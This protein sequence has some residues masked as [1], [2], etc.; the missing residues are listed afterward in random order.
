MIGAAA[1]AMFLATAVSASLLASTAL[2]VTAAAHAAKPSD[3]NGD[4]RADLAIGVQGE[5]IGS[6]EDAGAVNVLYGSSTGLSAKGNQLWSQ[7]SP[8]VKGASH[9]GSFESADNF[10][11]ALASG[12][13]DRDG[14]ADLAVGVPG[15]QVGHDKVRSGAVNVL[16]GS[17]SGLAAKGDQ[18][19][20]LANLPGVPHRWDGFG[21]ALA[22]GDFD[23]DGYWD[24]A[25]GVPGRDEGSAQYAGEAR[26]LYGGPTGLTATRAWAITTS[27]T[28]VRIPA[29]GDWFASA[30]AAGDVTGDGRADLAIGAP[31]GSA[32][33][34][35]VFLGGPGGLSSVGAQWWTQSSPGMDDVFDANDRFG[36]ALAIGDFDEDGHHDLAI[37]TPNLVIADE[38]GKVIILPGTEFGLTAIGRQIWDG[39]VP[40]T[41][42]IGALFGFALAAGDFDGDGHADLAVG[43]PLTG[44]RVGSVYVLY[45]GDGGLDDARAQLWS[46]ESAGVPGT[47]ED[48][49][50]FGA[51]VVA[52]DFDRSGQDD[53]AIGAPGESAHRMGVGRVTV[54]DGRAGGLSQTGIRTWT[55]DSRG[56]K[57]AAQSF[58]RF[59]ST[60]AGSRAA[61]DL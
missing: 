11:A 29:Q 45:G 35:G 12:D 26:V 38:F 14:Y 37:G 53:L 10:G 13:F 51:A 61:L 17:K 55:Q 30:L 36:A 24:L 9:G 25:I 50:V 5:D 19:W 1:R 18:L 32:R 16:Y 42:E 57:D 47:S 44:E 54:I 43:A 2:P 48:D 41:D 8:G 58:D 6:A 60:L 4:G 59:G 27:T 23:G 31:L 49:D 21:T 46:Q 40:G 39:P 33:G 52:L 15:D 20:S 7:D 28:G 34:V 3:F 22:S 56:V